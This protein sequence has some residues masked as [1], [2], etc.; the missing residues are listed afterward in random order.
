MIIATMCGEVTDKNIKDH[1]NEGTRCIEHNG[2]ATRYIGL[3]DDILNEIRQA[4]FR[5][6]E[7]EIKARKSLD[8]QDELFVMCR[9]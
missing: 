3:A 1:F 2:I 9:E 5:V 8:D 4:G 6:I 7:N